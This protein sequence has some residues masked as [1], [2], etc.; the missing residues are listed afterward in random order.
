VVLTDP[1]DANAQPVSP[2][3]STHVVPSLLVCQRTCAV[4]SDSST[5]NVGWPPA[6]MDTDAG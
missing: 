3:M 4:E 1:S 2:G 5:W 6:P